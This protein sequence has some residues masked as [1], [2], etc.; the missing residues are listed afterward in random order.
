M[1]FALF[2]LYAVLLSPFIWV[3]KIPVPG[4]LSP[5]LNG[6]AYTLRSSLD[7]LLSTLDRIPSIDNI[8]IFSS[9]FVENIVDDGPR[10][11]EI[12]FQKFHGFI[13]SLVAYPRPA[14]AVIAKISVPKGPHL[15]P[16]N[17]TSDGSIPVSSGCWLEVFWRLLMD[18]SQYIPLIPPSDPS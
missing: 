12:P 6:T 8:S 14:P 4:K 5:L 11:D 10:G 3:V 7:S 15:V 17:S 1:W 18:I 13:K 16:S 9:A 2:G